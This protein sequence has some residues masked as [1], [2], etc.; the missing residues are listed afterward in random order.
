MKVGQSTP[1][2]FD[3]P[4]SEV[5]VLA[6]GSPIGGEIQDQAGEDHFRHR[7][8]VIGGSGAGSP[9]Q[10]MR[11]SLAHQNPLIPIRLPRNQAGR[12]SRHVLSLLSLDVENVLVT[13][14][15]PAEEPER[16]MVLR[17]WELDDMTTTANIDL[18]T[19]Q[20]TEAAEVSLIETD[21]KPLTVSAGKVAVSLE[22]N[23]IKT[24][25]FIPAA[26]SESNLVKPGAVSSILL[27]LLDH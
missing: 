4:T 3:L 5:S 9:A 16:G 8:A 14:F 15:K 18:S 25:R 23:E 20:P 10:A 24:I 22:G 17:L 6:V 26:F 13:A 1:T 7:F 2:A 11:I 19:F 21:V 27:L 12:I